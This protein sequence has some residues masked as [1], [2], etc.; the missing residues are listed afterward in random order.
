MTKILRGAAAAGAFLAALTLP[1][2]SSAAVTSSPQSYVFQTRLIESFHP[3]EYDG[4]MRVTV[5]PDGI[6][7]GTFQDSDGGVRNVTGGLNGTSIWL[8][9]GAN[10]SLHLYGTFK[11]GTISATANLPGPD[12]YTFIATPETKSH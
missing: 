6:V 1:L 2:A 3:G 8:D 9:I 11:N 4:T 5:Y 12:S 7:S 10:H